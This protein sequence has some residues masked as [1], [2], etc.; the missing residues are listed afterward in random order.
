M[1]E[2]R[3]TTATENAVNFVLDNLWDRGERELS[4]LG[5]T[6]DMARAMIAQQR[7]AG[8][9]TMALWVDDEPVAISGL[10]RTDNPVGMCTWFQATTAF[11]AH[12]RPITRELRKKLA[13][14][15]EIYN[16]DYI[17]IVSPCVHEHT[18]RWFGAL[19]FR[20]D[21][22]RY[23]LLR[24]GSDQRLYRFERRFDQGG[25]RVLPQG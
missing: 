17:E 1:S 8:A 3:T 25:P 5:V 22:N 2:V 11:A 23:L 21:V 13:Y 10:L 20:L 15:A 24:E 12:A 7:N 16:L 19:G 6:T 18:G 9:P 4:I 14:A